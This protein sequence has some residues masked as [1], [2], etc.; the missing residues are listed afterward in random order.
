MPTSDDYESEDDCVAQMIDSG[1]DEDEAIIACEDIFSRRRH[2][3]PEVRSAPLEIRAKGRR[4]EGY[5]ATFNTEARIAD[6]VEIVAP[7]AFSKS[8]IGDVLALADHDPSRMLARTKS[9]TLRLVEDSRGL[10]FDL[11][12]P[13]T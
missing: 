1:M 9:G 3:K 4:L 13:A 5:A 6:F 2:F 10:Q 8:L 11:D 7:G 12:V